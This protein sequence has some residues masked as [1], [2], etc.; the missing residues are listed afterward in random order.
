MAI[1]WQLF[2]QI[3]CVFFFVNFSN[4]LI[5]QQ[6]DSSKAK[7]TF[8]SVSYL[9]SKW[10]LTLGYGASNISESNDFSACVGGI[11]TIESGYNFFSARVVHD[12]TAR[13]D[14]FPK[15]SVFDAS[16]LY[17]VGFHRE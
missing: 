14:V 17:G 16:I 15:Q 6:Q 11:M 1:K 10:W 2:G 9:K 12:Q 5:A 13:D 3:V 4:T 8:D 7:V